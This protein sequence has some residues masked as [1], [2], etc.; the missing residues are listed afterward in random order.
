MI[1]LDEMFSP[2]QHQLVAKLREHGPMTRSQLT[3]AVD[4]PRTTVYDN[5]MRLI[6]YGYVVKKPHYRNTR[7]RP[8]VY[9]YLMEDN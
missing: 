6:E 4:E 3:K 8:K 5:L 1:Q 9:Y 2:L 7:G